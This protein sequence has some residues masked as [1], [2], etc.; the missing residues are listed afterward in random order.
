VAEPVARENREGAGGPPVA[1]HQS[2]AIIGFAP[3]LRGV[4]RVGGDN[5]EDD[6]FDYGHQF[7]INNWCCCIAHKLQLCLRDVFEEKES[8]MKSLRQRI[9]TLLGKFHHSH[10][11]T[12]ELA[13]RTSKAIILPPDTRWS[14]IALTYERVVEI[15]NDLNA[16]AIQQSSA[17]KTWQR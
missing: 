12:K 13:E 11:A 7:P 1:P 15:V 9:F 14:Y 6:S 17:L 10:I 4:L 2:S 16:V 5:T 8:E 3:F